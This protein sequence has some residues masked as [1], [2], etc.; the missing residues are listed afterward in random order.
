MQACRKGSVLHQDRT[1]NGPAR[2]TGVR[3]EHYAGLPVGARMLYAARLHVRG[4]RH[5]HRIFINIWLGALA[6]SRK[7]GIM[8]TA[9]RNESIYLRTLAAFGN[10]GS[11]RS[12]GER[13]WPTSRL[14]SRHRHVCAYYKSNLRSKSYTYLVDSL[15][16]KRPPYRMVSLA[17]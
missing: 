10:T 6:V 16:A 7:W 13:Y 11:V 8:R 17:Q 9:V 3:Q 12:M 1:L 14:L 5:S 15:Q 2:A 4:V